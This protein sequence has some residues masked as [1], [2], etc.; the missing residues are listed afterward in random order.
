M[1]GGYRDSMLPKAK[2]VPAHAMKAYRGSGSIA[3]FILTLSTGWEVNCQHHDP[4][5]LPLTYLLHGAES[6]LRS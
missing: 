3:P 1:R 4:V 6:F 2:V 5:L